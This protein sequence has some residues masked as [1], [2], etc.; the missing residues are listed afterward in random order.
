MAD[1]PVA[2]DGLRPYEQQQGGYWLYGPHCDVY[3]NGKV[4]VPV[5]K[6][7]QD[8][9]I[10]VV[11]CPAC[12]EDGTYWEDRISVHESIAGFEIREAGIQHPDGRLCTEW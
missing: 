10:G 3:G 4:W 8:K 2:W 9:E 12:G 1:H 6:P 7:T 11:T 5:A